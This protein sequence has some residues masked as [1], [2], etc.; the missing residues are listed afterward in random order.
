MAHPN[1]WPRGLE[2]INNLVNKHPWQRERES[3]QVQRE[4]P[5][6]RGKSRELILREFL[7]PR[8]FQRN[9]FQ[10]AAI[11]WWLQR[12]ERDGEKDFFC[13]MHGLDC[14]LTWFPLNMERKTC[15]VLNYTFRGANP[16]AELVSCYSGKLFHSGMVPGLS[17]LQQFGVDLWN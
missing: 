8:S 5:D 10:L 3:D 4:E 14:H 17:E 2:N 16:Y 6:L 7:Q 12:V 11:G 1:L 9:D 15:I 13:P